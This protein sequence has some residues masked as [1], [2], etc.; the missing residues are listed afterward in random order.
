MREVNNIMRNEFEKIAQNNQ[1]CHTIILSVSTVATES[2][3]KYRRFADQT[4]WL[5]G[6][7]VVDKSIETIMNR[8]NV[9][10][11]IPIYKYHPLYKSYFEDETN[12][13]R[14]ERFKREIGLI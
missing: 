4:Y 6:H 10:Q 11:D 7:D 3:K 14:I 2:E 8:K 12:E 1:N 5:S 9:Y 13:Q